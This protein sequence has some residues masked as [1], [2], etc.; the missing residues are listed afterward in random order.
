MRKKSIKF[1]HVAF[2]I[3]SGKGMKTWVSG[4]YRAISPEGEDSILL[5]IGKP[6]FEVVHNERHINGF[7]FSEMMHASSLVY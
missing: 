2:W 5:S 4:N 1:K 6:A 3:V 7:F